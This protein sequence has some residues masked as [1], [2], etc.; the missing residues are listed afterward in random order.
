[1]IKLKF[2]NFYQK[3]YKIGYLYF[4]TKNKTQLIYLTKRS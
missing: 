1:M 3:L 4:F 2:N